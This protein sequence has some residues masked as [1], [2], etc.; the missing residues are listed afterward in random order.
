MCLVFKGPIRLAAE[1]C[2]GD[3][4]FIE[5]DEILVKFLGLMQLL[6]KL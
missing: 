4:F 1:S 6:K 3:L 5:F 2:P